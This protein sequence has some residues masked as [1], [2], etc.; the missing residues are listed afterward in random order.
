MSLQEEY[1]I[2]AAEKL[3][4]KVG[5]WYGPY[6]KNLGEELSQYNLFQNFKLDFFDY[7]LF[8]EFKEVYQSITGEK[9]EALEA[10]LK[11]RSKQYPNDFRKIVRTYKQKKAQNEF[12][13]GTRSKPDNY[14]GL[15]N[16]GSILRSYLKFLYY[17]EHPEKTYPVKRNKTASTEGVINY[18][19]IQPGA[20]AKYWDDFYRGD[21]IAIGWDYLGDSTIYESRDDV[22]EAIKEYE[23]LDYEPSNSSLAVWEFSQ[24]MKPGDIVYVKQGV[25]KL[26]GR[27]KITGD[28]LFEENREELR[29]TRKVE[30]T[31]HGEWNLDENITP[32]V[33]TCFTKYTNWILETEEMFAGILEE[34]DRS[35]EQEY[36]EWLS[37]KK[38]SDGHLYDEKTI[39]ARINALR[40]FE[41]DFSV[42]IFNETDIK[43]LEE[44]RGKILN[45]EKEGSYS[46]HTSNIRTSMDSFIEFIDTKP[47]DIVI[48]ND[49]YEDDDFLN[50]VFMDKDE[51]QKLK[52]ILRNKKN[53]IFKGAPGVGKTYVADRLAYTLMGEKDDSRIHFV[54]FHQSYSYED[55]IEG[56]R[57]KED[58]DGFSLVTGPFVTFCEK[59]K[60]DNRPY[61]FIVDEINRGNMSR[62]FGE[63]MML[64]EADKRGKE[65]NLLY[66]NRLFSVPKN[67][68]IIGTMNTADRS[69]AMLDYALRRRFAFYD[70]KPA[71]GKES[72]IEYIKEYENTEL[73]VQFIE[74]IKQ[75]NGRIRESFGD[76][77]Q[78]GHSYFTD[79]AIKENTR[80]R[81]QEVVEYEIYPQLREYWFDDLDIANKE[82]NILRSSLN[83]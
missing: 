47:P 26:L 78:I 45:E 55:F 30:W 77:F 73:M 46:K 7:K 49:S 11:G 70:L 2:W 53:L 6:L 41:K 31:H 58:G 37:Q 32:K 59:A 67:V 43:S 20:H 52:S 8:E 12:R 38:R 79:S 28:Y 68:Y 51:L 36:A 50:E 76:G 29:H 13:N 9:D 24:V 42:S 83:E 44:I 33:L 74:S 35:K 21:F 48:G 63:M 54:Q 1:M 34:K 80:G 72:F 66:S 25:K 62:I 71:F 5:M 40:D 60:Q 15:A 18:W 65:I 56:Y 39:A 61:F 17:R 64:I 19:I 22:Q 82:V 16:L 3:G 81:L 69:L 75:L 57:P 27:G 10:I 23:E 14:G 4:P